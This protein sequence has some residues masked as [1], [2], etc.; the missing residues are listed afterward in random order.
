MSV[1]NQRKE[2]WGVKFLTSGWLWGTALTVCFYCALPSLPVYRE[3]AQ[4][5]FTAHW[6]EYATT[7][8]FL[9]GMSTLVF[10]SLRIPAERTA[11]QSDV[12]V[13]LTSQSGQSAPE[14]A[15]HIENHL[16]LVARQSADSVVVRRVREL[17]DYVRARRSADGLESHLTYLAE[18]GSGRLHESYALIRT[19]TWAVPILGFLGTVIG[20]T[21]AI[22]NVTPDQLSSSLNEV[23]AGLA[24]AFDTTA[25]SLALSMILVFTTFVVERAEQQHLDGVEDFL[26][27]RLTALFPA[28][29]AP[30]SPLLAAES[31]AADRLL[32][33][34]ETLIALQQEEWRHSLQEARQRWSETLVRQQDEL[35][36]NLK[37]AVRETVGD[38]G[39]QLALLRS[40]FE[41]GLT[42]SIQTLAAS[43]RQIQ[44]EA[45]A[46]HAESREEVVRTWTGFR[47]DLHSAAAQQI[48][49]VNQMM[50]SLHG[51]VSGWQG[52]LRDATATA[53]EQLQ[54]IRRQGEVLSRLAHGRKLQVHRRTVRCPLGDH[55][56]TDFDRM[57]GPGTSFSA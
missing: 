23:T 24:V 28:E 56:P 21:M 10:K 18:I 12:L 44:Q 30:Q 52:D 5:Y 39:N 34:M 8:L 53:Q 36:D 49:L 27:Q 47:D 22:A 14:M 46:D 7:W 41:A 3:S 42:R 57:H 6:I 2:N 31:A 37:I 13:G 9:V 51:A 35:A 45:H 55:T 11:L 1:S 25:L 29:A 43:W 32:Q 15:D 19:I 50:Q 48:Q 38:H 16:K 17:C 26:V 33:E 4:R 40:E 20:I 54:E